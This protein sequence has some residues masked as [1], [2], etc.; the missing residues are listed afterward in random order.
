MRDRMKS[1]EYLFDELGLISDAIITEAAEYRGNSYAR[2]SSFRRILIAAAVMMTFVTVLT[3]MFVIGFIR[4]NLVVKEDLGESYPVYSQSMSEA[5]NKAESSESV[6]YCS[7]DELDLFDGVTKLI[8]QSEDSDGYYV[9]AIT[10]T[11]DKNA[12]DRAL[13]STYSSANKSVSESDENVSVWIS[14][15]DGSVTS[16][17][18]EKSEGNVGYGELFNYSP[19]I[20]PSDS[21]VRFVDDLIS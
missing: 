18:L 11:E 14:F 19:E 17:Y 7:A 15:G 12:L 6:I 13:N 16:P 10:N 3:A 5:L 1:A 4:E 9:M 20:V 8:W 2:G 21:L